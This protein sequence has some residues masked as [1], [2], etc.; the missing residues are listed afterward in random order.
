MADEKNTEN[1]EEQKVVLEREYIV[2]LRAG[3]LKVPL[4]KRAKKALK[5]LKEFMV[6]H[7]KVYDRDLRKIKVDVYLNNE[8]RFQGMRKPLAK[9]KVK[10][11]KYE[12][13]EVIVKLAELPKHIE[14]E[15]ARNARRQAEM[16]AKPESKKAEE[17]AEAK[18][19]AQ[20]ETKEEKKEETTKTEDI[21]EKETASKEAMQAIEKTKAK[22]VQHTSK[23]N[24]TNKES[25]VNRKS[26][27]K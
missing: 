2:P 5:T 10:A 7:M 25:K 6:K 1:K 14:F 3:W 17:K 18:S 19:E 22:E 11:I 27:R 24:W 16:L 9:V 4:Y 21:K 20:K 13:G 23:E 26:L 12:N 8:I 15:I